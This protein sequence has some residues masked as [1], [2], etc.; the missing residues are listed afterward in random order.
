MFVLIQ[1]DM[2]Q[3]RDVATAN[4]TVTIVFVLAEK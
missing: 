1:F 2:S 3:Q 4:P